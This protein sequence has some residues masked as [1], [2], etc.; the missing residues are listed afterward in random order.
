METVMSNSP[1]QAIS[2][3]HQPDSGFSLLEMVVAMFILTIGLLGAA[4][5]I[6][7][8]LMVSNSGRGLTNA[9]LLVVSALEQMETLRDSGQLNFAEISNTVQPSPSTFTAFPATFIPVSTTPGP[10]FVYG[11]V[12]DPGITNSALAVNGVTRQ[13]LITDL[14]A[15][16]KQ[17]KVTLKYTG[18]GTAK[19]P[20]PLVCVSYLNDDAH[21]NYVP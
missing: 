10:D 1:T 5:A 13:I 17:I 6:G 4:Q 9:K 21:G 20:A 19:P 3:R 11:T 18:Y 15:T 8:A 2:H 16:L 14:S 12:D 7:Y